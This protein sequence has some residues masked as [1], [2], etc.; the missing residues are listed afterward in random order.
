MLRAKLLCE[1]RRRIAAAE[2]TAEPEV[3]AAPG[4]IAEIQ[5]ADVEAATG[6]AE[7]TC[8]EKDVSDFAISIFFPVLRDKMGIFVKSV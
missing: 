1:Q 7:Y 5:T 6:V 4:T 8:P 2:A 3:E